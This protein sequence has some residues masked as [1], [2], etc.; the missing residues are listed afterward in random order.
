[1]RIAWA[2]Y[3][4]M[5][6]LRTHGLNCAILALIAF[7][8]LVMSIHCGRNPADLSDR[9]PVKLLREDYQEL[10]RLVFASH[11]MPFVDR[12]EVLKAFDQHRDLLR[13]SLTVL[14]FY[15]IASAAV[16]AVGC[17]H[18]ELSLPERLQ[19]Q[20]VKTGGFFP[21]AIT[22]LH[23]SLFVR[24]DYPDA[25][26]L[27][28]GTII[29]SINGRPASEILGKLRDC[30]PTDG[31]YLVKKDF[32]LSESFNEFY[33][34]FVEDIDSFE[35][36]YV[37]PGANETSRSRVC[38]RTWKEVRSIAQD[39][40]CGRAPDRMRAAIDDKAGY[41]ILTIPFFEY[42]DERE[43]FVQTVDSLFATFASHAVHSLILDLRGNQGGDPRSAAYLLGYLIPKPFAYFSASSV[44][45]HAELKGLQPIHENR[46]AGKLIV[47]VNGGVSSTTGHLCSLL[48]YHRVGIILGTETG[49]SYACS[50]GFTEHDLPNTR[51]HLLLPHAIFM[52]AVGRMPSAYRIQPD[53]EIEPSISDLLHC[54]DRQLDSAKAAIHE[55]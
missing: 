43:H 55:R 51:L 19:Q 30:L 31:G 48:K 27:P 20:L 44:N 50:G 13:D 53:V 41:A 37:L 33:Q 1:M 11:P 21:A 45:L 9:L 49:G 18:T 36:A 34:G 2:V 39:D 46:F 32:L 25:W 7:V 8:F 38:A 15:R 23:D 54:T 26:S 42:G 47:M 3:S 5:T 17:S 4:L 52:A 10:Q 35:I 6:H 28:T 24:T 12:A 14:E 29:I 16:A 40:T 22:V